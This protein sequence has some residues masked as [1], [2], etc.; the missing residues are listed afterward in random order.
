LRRLGLREV[1]SIPNDAS[2]S[3]QEDILRL[4]FTL[5]DPQLF[6]MPSWFVMADDEKLD[7]RE[8]DHAKLLAGIYR[9]EMDA[10]GS[11]QEKLAFA[12]GVIDAFAEME[13]HRNG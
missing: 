1:P 11:Y 8:E 10:L 6:P 12:A 2:K 3:K 5:I 13:Q 7:V 9:P 4:A